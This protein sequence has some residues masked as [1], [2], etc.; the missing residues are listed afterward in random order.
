MVPL[1]E[2]TK[3][4]DMVGCGRCDHVKLKVKSTAEKL[5]SESRGDKKNNLTKLIQN[6]LSNESLK[7]F[8]RA[9]HEQPRDKQR[10]TPTQNC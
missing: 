1:G 3:I 7:T 6:L 4:Q 10:N 9:E 8:K 5:L 2:K